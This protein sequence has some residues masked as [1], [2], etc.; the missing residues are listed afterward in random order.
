[1]TRERTERRVHP[2]VPLATTVEVEAEGRSFLAVVGIVSAAGMLICT[3]NPAA[4]GQ[5]LHLTFQVPGTERVI[6]TAA[7]V[8]YV[9]PSTSMGVQFIG[10]SADDVAALREFTARTTL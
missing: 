7:I 10:L 4:E 1:M 6:R 2:R 3:G 5:K 9:L 8:R